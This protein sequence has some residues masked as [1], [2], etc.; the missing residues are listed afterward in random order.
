MPAKPFPRTELEI[1]QFIR[2][3]KETL[4]TYS[5]T[6]GI[7]PAMLTQLEEDSANFDYL[8][9]F[10]NSLHS[11]KESYQD[12]KD[13]LF[14]DATELVPEAPGFASVSMPGP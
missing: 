8:L 11:F 3:L 7:P 12:F 4:T 9:D 13:A 6:L 1:G 10:S 5:V 14:D 2:H